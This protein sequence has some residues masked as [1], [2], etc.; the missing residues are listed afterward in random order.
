MLNPLFKAIV[1][2]SIKQIKEIKV[3]SCDIVIESK[4]GE[5]LH[6]DKAALEKLNADL[7][8]PFSF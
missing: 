6:I 8:L 3:I 2:E 1:V 5:I 4:S 7:K